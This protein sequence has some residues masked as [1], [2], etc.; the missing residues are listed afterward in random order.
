MNPRTKI[1]GRFS[2][3]RKDLA[4]KAQSLHHQD[5][6]FI[7]G[8][9]KGAGGLA[10]WVTG[11]KVLVTFHPKVLQV[12]HFFDIYIYSQC[13]DN[14]FD[15]TTNK[16]TDTNIWLYLKHNVFSWYLHVDVFNYCVDEKQKVLFL[17]QSLCGWGISV[18]E[19][20]QNIDEIPNRPRLMIAVF[21]IPRH[22]GDFVKLIDHLNKP[23]HGRGHE[24][25]LPH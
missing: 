18:N 22:L 16:L 14:Y 2:N 19:T 5:E 4:I 13:F 21:E 1:I 6:S 17:Q 10:W 24:I 3:P 8:R 20:L 9:C 12:W 15:I 23:V 7:L 25:V 11:K